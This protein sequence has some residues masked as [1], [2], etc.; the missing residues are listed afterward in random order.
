MLLSVREHYQSKLEH[1]L[2]M[3]KAT[4]ESHDSVHPDRVWSFLRCQA[5]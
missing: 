3:D 1:S 4:G 5:E 2:V